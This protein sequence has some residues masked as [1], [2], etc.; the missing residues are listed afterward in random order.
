MKTSSSSVI[1]SSTISSSNGKYTIN[2]VTY[3]TFNDIP[4]DIR[5]Q[6]GLTDGDGNG[7]SDQFDALKKMLNTMPQGPTQTKIMI[8]GKEYP[9][10]DEVPAE[11]QGQKD[12]FDQMLGQNSSSFS[13]P[14][15]QNMKIIPPSH[16]SSNSPF[17]AS[18][19]SEKKRLWI[20]L[21]VLFDLAVIYFFLG[22]HIKAWLG[23]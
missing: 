9:S 18:S 3:E 15:N 10:W 22:D 1:N 8:N 11:F 19:A 4:N 23:I 14:S 2:G 13:K 21:F 5:Q 16:Y 20:A 12:L 7:E 6:F 17:A